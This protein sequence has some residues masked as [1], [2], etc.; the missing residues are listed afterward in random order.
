[1]FFQIPNKEVEFILFL[2]QKLLSVRVPKQ[3]EMNN[4]IDCVTDDEGNII[5]GVTISN[6]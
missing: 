4:K 6:I 5:K 1:M 2:S 3:M